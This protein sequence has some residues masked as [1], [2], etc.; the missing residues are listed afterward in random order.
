MD[1]GGVAKAQGVNS[2]WNH[3]EQQGEACSGT[4]AGR[5]VG[6]TMYTKRPILALRWARTTDATAKRIFSTGESS[7]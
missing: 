4:S 3:H 7:L 5:C 1:K 6:R 2:E